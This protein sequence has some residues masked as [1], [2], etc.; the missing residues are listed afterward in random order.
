MTI[1]DRPDISMQRNRHE[2]KTSPQ[3]TSQTAHHTQKQR[4]TCAKATW[5]SG[6]TTT[7]TSDPAS[8]HCESAG[9]GGSR[10]AHDALHRKRASIRLRRQSAHTRSVISQQTAPSQ[11]PRLRRHEVS[12]LNRYKSTTTQSSEG[13]CWCAAMQQR[14]DAQ[15]SLKAVH[16]GASLPPTD[17]AQRPVCNVWLTTL[18]TSYHLNGC[19]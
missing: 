2:C 19:H 15:K 14:C 4:F 5:R 1:R 8:A 6:N 12:I 17:L 18:S 10:R 7:T 3:Q 16:W 13:R 11:S 9:Q